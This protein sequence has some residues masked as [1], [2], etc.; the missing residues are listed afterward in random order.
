MVRGGV[1]IPSAHDSATHHLH[2]TQPPNFLFPDK[3]QQQQQQQQQQQEHHQQQQQQLLLL[4]LVMF[5]CRSSQ[6]Q[7]TGS[8]RLELCQVRLYIAGHSSPR[9]HMS[10][11]AARYC[12]DLPRSRQPGCEC[13]CLFAIWL[14]GFMAYVSLRWW[15]LHG[16]SLAHVTTPPPPS[17]NHTSRPILLS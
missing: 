2:S 11:S 16:G 1:C 14:L 15:W 10:G 4:Q 9:L 8:P 3:E 5:C 12:E 7:D 17:C 13:M 6:I